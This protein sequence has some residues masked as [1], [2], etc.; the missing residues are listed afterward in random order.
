MNV[1]ESQDA[2]AFTD[3]LRRYQ[4]TICGRHPIGVFMQVT[5]YAP[6]SRQWKNI[7]ADDKLA[8]IL[9]AALCCVLQA[10]AYLRKHGNGHQYTV[11]FIKYDQSSRCVNNRDSSVSYASAALTIRWLLRHPTDAASLNIISLCVVSAL[12]FD[13]SVIACTCVSLCLLLYT[14]TCIHGAAVYQSI[15]RFLI[16][17]LSG[18]YAYLLHMRWLTGVFHRQQFVKCARV[19]VCACKVARYCMLSTSEPIVS[20]FCVCFFR[21]RSWRNIEL[22]MLSLHLTVVW[23][24]A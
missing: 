24:C 10:L 18:L 23:Y 3:Y 1:I 19:C 8:C 14:T 2:A 15:N 5:H 11:K 4:N 7:Q 22:V 17:G 12:D 13:L 9:Y 21:R 6:T 20:L 16:G